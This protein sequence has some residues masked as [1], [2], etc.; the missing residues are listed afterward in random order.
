MKSTKAI[1]AGSSVTTKITSQAASKAVTKKAWIDSFSNTKYLLYS[2]LITSLI[3]CSPKSPQTISGEIQGDNTD[4]G[5]VNG[6]AVKS[7]DPIAKSTVGLKL[8]LS[9][10]IATCTGTLISPKVI[11]TAAHCVVDAS[12][13][14]AVFNPAIK[15]APKSKMRPLVQVLVHPNYQPDANKN[16]NDLALIKLGGGPLPVG[17]TPIDYLKDKSLLKDG[18]LATLAGYGATAMVW[19]QT[20][21]ADSLRQ[22]TVVLSDSK[23]SDDEVLFQQYKGSGACH[24]DSGGPAY[25]TDLSGHMVVFGVTS[26]S[27]T[28][29]GGSNCLE[30]SIYTNTAAY[31]DFIAKGVASLEAS[32]F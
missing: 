32:A 1:K 27:A 25:T 4:S 22:A 21:G 10:G 14:L 29:A 17:A 11:L 20:V 28:P 24:G 26:R 30:G 8:K 7:V 2:T 15:N 16:S 12:A 6:L 3:A 19:G 9:G 18:M 23:F 31:S 5:I 13:G